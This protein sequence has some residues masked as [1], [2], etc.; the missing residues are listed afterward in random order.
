MYLRYDGRVETHREL[1]RS[2][3]V[4]GRGKDAMST[5][6]PFGI[7]SDCKALGAAG[8]RAF[9]RYN[10]AALAITLCGL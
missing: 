5:Q 3:V 10:S 2:G 8:D 6:V 1:R 4:L 7:G 9:V